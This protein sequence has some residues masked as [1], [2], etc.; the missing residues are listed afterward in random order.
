M[1]KL[2]NV[3]L[4]MLLLCG[5][6]ACQKQVTG[7]KQEP[8]NQQN[9]PSYVAYKFLKAFLQSD[10]EEEQRLIY[11]KGS[12]EVDKNAEKQSIAFS[13]K[14]IEGIK[15]Y[16]D[17]IDKVVFVWIKYDNPHTSST[18]TRVYAVRKNDEG[19]YKVDMDAGFDFS[20]IQQKIEPTVINPKSLG[21]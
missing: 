10:Y 8:T 5:L 18:F 4:A 19:D 11:K 21:E 1:K 7:N 6:A 17:K 13:P 15:E 16:N 12:Y 14:N 20:F 2:F 3:S 9:T